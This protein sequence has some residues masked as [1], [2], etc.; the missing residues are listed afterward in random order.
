MPAPASLANVA[1]IEDCEI[2]KYSAAVG[3]NTTSVEGGAASYRDGTPYAELDMFLISGSIDYELSDAFLL[4]SNSSYYETKLREGD[5]Q[6]HSPYPLL[7]ST[8]RNV[9]TDFQQELR[10]TSDLDSPLN[11]MAG[12]YF[13]DGTYSAHPEAHLAVLGALPTPYYYVDSRTYAVFG[14]LTLDLLDDKLQLSAGG[15]YSDEKRTLEADLLGMAV[16]DVFASKEVNSSSFSPEVTVSFRPNNRTNFFVTYK[17]GVKSGGFAIV[18]VLPPDIT[19]FDL[20]FRDEVAEGIEGGVKT[21]VFDDQLRF[22]L[23]AYRYDYSDFQV[24]VFDP[25]TSTTGVRNAAEVRTWG[26]QL[27]TNFAPDSVPG[28]NIGASVNYGNARFREYLANCYTGQTQ[29]DGCI[30]R[31]DGTV[32]DPVA[33]PT[34]RA[35]NQDLSGRPLSAAPDWTG[36][37]N[38]NY[39]FDISG[40]GTR[41]GLSASATYQDKYEVLYNQP[42]GSQQSK[43]VNVDAT[44]RLFNDDDGWELALIGK[45][46]TDQ[47]RVRWGAEVFSAPGLTVDPLTG[48]SSGDGIRSDNL[49]FTNAPRTIMLRLTFKPFG[50]N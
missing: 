46:L 43:A 11:G 48:V 9:R 42:P 47:L 14:Q 19:D 35:F 20:S 2:N 30:Y 26:V 24:T 23:T 32:V 45:N 1:G 13:Q 40:G 25:T 5:V 6:T 41:L 22:D 21:V 33:D 44:L 27:N 10:V 18:S 15:R 12:V 29:A 31:L 7:G 49:G 38:A 8:V 34:E 17:K 37:I 3:R 36:N 39:D 28:L 50:D 4:S 16:E